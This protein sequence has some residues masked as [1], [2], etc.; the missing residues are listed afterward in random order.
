MGPQAAGIERNYRS[1]LYWHSEIPMLW[2]SGEFEG[3]ISIQWQV[4]EIL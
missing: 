1:E 4:K 3:S 2:L